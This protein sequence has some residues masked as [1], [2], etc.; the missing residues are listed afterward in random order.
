MQ[1]RLYFSLEAVLKETGETGE[2]W[3]TSAL[4]DIM[5]G[6]LFW[7]ILIVLL[8]NELQKKDGEIEKIYV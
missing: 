8:Q 6:R 2:S 3:N 1:T 7:K 5:D 4:P